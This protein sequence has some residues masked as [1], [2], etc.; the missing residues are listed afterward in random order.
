MRKRHN[1]EPRMERCREYLEVIS[2]TTIEGIEKGDVLV[3][4]NGHLFKTRTEALA[5]FYSEESQEKFKY[6]VVVETT[7]NLVVISL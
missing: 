3:S 2:K 6:E 4:V 5:Y 7:P 1:L